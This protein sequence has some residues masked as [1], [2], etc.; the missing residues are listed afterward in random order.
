M[1]I[2]FISLTVV[3]NLCCNKMMS[4]NSYNSHK[5][6][7]FF[8]AVG[9]MAVIL[10]IP[11][12]VIFTTNSQ[13][14]LSS[15][16]ANNKHFQENI[17]QRKNMYARKAGKNTSGTQTELIPDYIYPVNA[18]GYPAPQNEGASI[19][20]HLCDHAATNGDSSTFIANPASGPGSAADA[21]W[22]AAIQHCVND[23]VNVVGYVH[24]SYGSR[25]LSA[26][27]A[28]VAA[29][30][31]LY[32]DT[33]EGIFID[34]VPA[35]PNYTACPAGG[36]IAHDCE[37]YYSQLDGYIR[38]KIADSLIVA[39]M[40]AAPST[41]WPISKSAMNGYPIDLVNIFEGNVSS[42][43]SWTAPSWVAADNAGDSVSALIYQDNPTAD[44]AGTD[45]TSVCTRLKQD[46]IRTGVAWSNNNGN[47]W[48]TDP[49]AV[50]GNGIF[51]DFRS[52][53]C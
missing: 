41:D 15:F 39:N 33:V 47:N 43:S 2:L 29:W 48:S 7:T 23:G 45:A 44:T 21:N 49:T 38:S 18:P 9:I 3:I 6:R 5:R 34:E 32:G 28:D 37:R 22:S 13:N 25:S 42:F 27:E 11:F 14:S 35:D 1:A 17:S 26:V 52:N 19:A 10:G 30:V 51:D 40:G 20:N 4:K 16:A 53:G 46:G 12:A 50:T 24:T 36:S 31:S 8:A